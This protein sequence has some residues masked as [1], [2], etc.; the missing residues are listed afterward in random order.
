MLYVLEIN[1]SLDYEK[2]KLFS[3]TWLFSTSESPM[4]VLSQVCSLQMAENYSS[5]LP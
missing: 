2:T 1:G 5:T 4:S 3:M